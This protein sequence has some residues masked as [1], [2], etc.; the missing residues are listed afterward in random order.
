VPSL[1][2]RHRVTAAVAALVAGAPPLLPGLA[3]A[4]PTPGAP[5]RQGGHEVVF[6]GGG[7]L[8]LRCAATPNVASVTVPAEGLLRVVNNTGR[9]ASLMLDGVARGEIAGGSSGEVLVHRGPV[10]LTL[11]P[12][13]LFASPT[14]VQVEVVAP[15]PVRSGTAETTNRAGTWADPAAAEPT[16]SVEPLSAEEPIGLLA[17]TAT[18]CVVGVSAGAIR[19]MMAQR[20]SR[21]S[22][23]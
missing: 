19:A 18:V 10:S 16:D 7:S 17:L 9:R 14:P 12:H 13:C 22:V 20:I 23:A 4:E 21:T 8:G 3:V 15:R 6:S 2:R 5:T 11:R 1:L